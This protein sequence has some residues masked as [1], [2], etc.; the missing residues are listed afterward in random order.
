V[1]LLETASAGVLADIEVDDV[2]TFEQRLM[3]AARERLAELLKKIGE[4]E[5]VDEADRKALLAV[6]NE[7]KSKSRRPA[8]DHG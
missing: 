7:I 6:A 2:R 8:Q 5:E 4:G 1:I 3:A